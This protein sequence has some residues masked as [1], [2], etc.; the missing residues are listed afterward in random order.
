M[1]PHGTTKDKA[2]FIWLC[3]AHCVANRICCFHMYIMEMYWYENHAGKDFSSSSLFSG[4][5]FGHSFILCITLL[6]YTN[7][8]DDDDNF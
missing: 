7:D 2:S 4:L 1:V 8:D 6:L 5:I 3:Y